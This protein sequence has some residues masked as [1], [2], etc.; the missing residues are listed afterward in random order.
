MG[1]KTEN[2]QSES[3]LLIEEE[4]GEERQTLQDADSIDSRVEA[5]VRRLNET[6]SITDPLERL[7]NEKALL[8][9]LAEDQ[10]AYDQLSWDN[11]WAHMFEEGYFDALDNT[12]ETIEHGAIAQPG[13]STSTV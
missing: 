12:E 13:M 9:L 10:D 2:I 6:Q 5:F 11:N 1:K 4:T 7:A 3:R 8:N